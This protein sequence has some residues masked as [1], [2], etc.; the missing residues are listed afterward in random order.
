MENKIL[1]EISARHAHLSDAH[2]EILFGKGHKLHNI[3]ELSQP[4][5]YA[6]EERISIKGPRGQ[7]DR[8][9]ILGPTRSETQVEVS[10]TDARSLGLGA[11][12]RMSG[13][14]EGS[15]GCTIIG[16]KGEIELEKGVI[17]AKRHI[18]ATPAEAAKFNIEDGEKVSVRID[19]NERSLTFD[20]V[21]VRVNENFSAAM[22][23]DTDEGNAANISGSTI[24]TIIK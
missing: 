8:V 24:G 10:A 15:A 11:P 20:D 14:I 3:K 22:H 19:T 9:I 13:D 5:Q 1:V 7:M 12:I 2:L 21:V 23:I 6:T 4:G 17:V 18:H 16:P